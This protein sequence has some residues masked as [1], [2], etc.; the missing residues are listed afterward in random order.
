[1]TAKVQF[2]REGLYGCVHRHM[3]VWSAALKFDHLTLVT[4]GLPGFHGLTFDR[5]DAATRISDVSQSADCIAISKV[6]LLQTYIY[7]SFYRFQKVFWS[8]A[9]FYLCRRITGVQLSACGQRSWE[10]QIRSERRTRDFMRKSIMWPEEAWLTGQID[11]SSLKIAH[12]L[13]CAQ[14]YE[15]ICFY[16]SQDSII[17]VHTYTHTLTHTL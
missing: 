14:N 10:V 11:E 9:R 5:C 3:C 2:N 16:A 13:I 15:T 4:A 6:I 1:M 7:T 8:P 17:A 12:T